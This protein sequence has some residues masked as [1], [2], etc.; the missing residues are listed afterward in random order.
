MQSLFR[1]CVLLCLY[2]LTGTEAAAQLRISKIQVDLSA[3]D[4]SAKTVPVQF[5]IEQNEA[6]RT[7]DNHDATWVFGKFERAPGVWADMRFTSAVPEIEGAQAGESL[8][9][10]ASAGHTAGFLLSRSD[11]GRGQIAF[12]VTARWHYGASYY[13]LPAEGTAISIHGVEMVY[14]PAGPFDLGEGGAADRKAYSFYSS[15]AQGHPTGPYRVTS[16]AEIP[17]GTTENDLHYDVPEGEAYAGGDQRGPV[18]AAFPKGVEGFYVMKYPVTQAQYAAFLTALPP[19]ARAAR[20]PAVSPGYGE[21]GGSIRCNGDGC[22]AEVPDRAANFLTWADGTG[23]AA[24]AGLRPMT[25]FE[26]EKAAAG[27]KAN[28]ARY[29]DGQLPDA[30]Y[31]SVRKSRWGVVDL[32]GGLWERVVSVGT[33]EGRKYTGSPG[34]GFVDDMG[35][36]YGFANGDWPGPQ[37]L[38]SGYRGGTEGL[39]GMSAVAD[40]TYGGYEATYGNESQGFRAV[41]SL[42]KIR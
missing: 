4:T 1:W 34:P 10:P 2:C 31:R 15:D 6:W 8:P 32:C 39:L 5:D 28:V 3:R 30:V 19:R 38:G 40:R 17:V 42:P 11:I 21:K 29:K 26:Y 23:W 14:I 41:L 33:A 12:Q 24:W 27:T 20:N 35:Y 25:E 9:V 18:P 37:A 16:S 36:P 7:G 13:E 22:N